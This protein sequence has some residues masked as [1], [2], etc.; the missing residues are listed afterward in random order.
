MR[1]WTNVLSWW[2]GARRRLTAKQRPR[3]LTSP[4]C[5]ISSIWNSTYY[6]F[7]ESG[8]LLERD[9]GGADGC[10][11]IWESRYFKSLADYK[12][13]VPDELSVDQYFAWLTDPVHLAAL[14]FS[15]SLKAYFAEVEETEPM[16]LTPSRPGR[17]R[18]LHARPAAGVRPGELAHIQ[19]HGGGLGAEGSVRQES[20]T[21]PSVAVWSRASAHA[22]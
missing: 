8:G 20:R 15:R 19:V 2:V 6:C 5:V 22:H 10:I 21:I 16:R 12:T 1:G 14:P 11:D 13:A 17:R 18:K 9:D 4:R 3:S 7:G